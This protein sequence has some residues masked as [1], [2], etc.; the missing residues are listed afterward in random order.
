MQHQEY[1]TLSHSASQPASIH[2]H[3]YCMVYMGCYNDYVKLCTL[4]FS[5]Q[6]PNT[7]HFSLFC[8]FFFLFFYFVLHWWDTERKNGKK[9]YMPLKW[10]CLTNKTEGAKT[11]IE[12]MA[13]F[14]LLLAKYE[15]W[16]WDGWKY[17]SKLKL[18][19]SRTVLVLRNA[20][21][22]MAKRQAHIQ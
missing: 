13:Q 14:F 17:K 12:F 3:I 10:M 18:N 11:V 6:K 19:A 15:Q 21:I 16:I 9:F 1:V 20:I 22:R 8:F 2:I 4:L 5:H 7:V